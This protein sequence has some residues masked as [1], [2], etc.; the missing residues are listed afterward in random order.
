V[1]QRAI[2]LGVI[3][4]S[5]VAA[6]GPEALSLNVSLLVQA[7][8]LVRIGMGSDAALR[9]LAEDYGLD[10]ARTE[11]RGR[12]WW[13]AASARADGLIVVAAGPHH[14]GPPPEEP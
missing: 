10:Q 14:Q 13:R 4:R 6:I 12:L 8:T 7:W 5:Q 2:D 9:A 11:R 1:N 3:W